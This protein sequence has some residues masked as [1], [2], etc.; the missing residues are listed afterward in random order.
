MIIGSDWN[1]KYSTI[2]KNTICSG[3]PYL[4]LT[5]TPIYQKTF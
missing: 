3:L 4:A 1:A 2:S 5:E